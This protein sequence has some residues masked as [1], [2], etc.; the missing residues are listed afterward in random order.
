MM[1]HE[2]R[3]APGKVRAFLDMATEALRGDPALTL[4]LRGRTGR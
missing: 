4:K 1:Q 2:G 3:H